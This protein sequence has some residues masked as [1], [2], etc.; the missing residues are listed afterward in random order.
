MIDQAAS[1]R[2]LMRGRKDERQRVDL[3]ETSGTPYTLAITSGKGGVGKTSIAVNLSLLLA[4]MGRQVWFVDADFGLAN[5]EVLLGVAPRF[6]LAHVLRGTVDLASAWCDVADGVR[7]LSS[8]SGLEDAANIGAVQVASLINRVKE[9]AGSD[10]LVVVDT[11]PGIDDPVISILTAADEV[12]VVTTPEPTALT[13][14]YATM[15]VLFAR[16]P[17]SDVTLVINCCESPSQADSLAKALGDVCRRFLTTSFRRYQYLP[18][19]KTVARAIQAQ[20]PLV[21]SSYR[22]RTEPWLR[23]LAVEIDQRIR[24]RQ[25]ALLRREDAF[26]TSDAYR[27]S[28]IGAV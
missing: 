27:S 16:R 26:Q 23:K 25:L 21:F 12:V 22:N 11:G 20:K 19:D 14:C 15:K 10:G 17:E 9:T 18:V 1:L 24:D 2:E 8:G 6:N 7:L 5:A 28:V 4:R 3:T 13:D